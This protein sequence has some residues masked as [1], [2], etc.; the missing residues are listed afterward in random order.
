MNRLVAVLAALLVLAPILALV[1][2]AHEQ[3]VTPAR[4]PAALLLR[5]EPVVETSGGTAVAPAVRFEVPGEDTLFAMAA[6][7]AWAYVESQYQPNT[8]F[9]NSVINYPYATIWDMGSSLAALHCAEALGLV[10]GDEYDRRMTRALQTLENLRLFDGAGF[11]KTYQL[12]NG[13]PA[14]RDDRDR[15]Y[16]AG[17]Y[18]WSVTDIGRLLVWLKIISLDR[19]EYA[20]QIERIVARLDFDRLVREGYLWGSSL[21]RSGSPWAYQEG[22][23]GY[24]QYAA[25]GFA[26]WDQ[27]AD[28]ALDLRQ[29][30]REVEVLGVPILTDRRGESRLTSEPFFMMGLELGW[31]TPEWRELAER[32]L[33]VQENRYRETGRLTMVSED[34]M[35]HPPYYFYYYTLFHEGEDFAVTA[36][37]P[38]QKFANPRW[39]STKAAFAWYA[40]M[41]DPYTWQVLETVAG[42]A[43]HPAVGWSSGV[44]EESLEPTGS[45]NINTSA[46]ILEA[47]LYHQRQRPLLAAR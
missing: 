9:A 14:G 30:T 20:T 2:P 27:F 11:N 16:A 21:N 38:G 29:N 3:P 24:E 42:R 36:V 46:I 6:R 25:A 31:W 7:R 43:A 8:G 10:E 26:L 1:L 41:P 37:V 15:Q 40:L 39:V 47:A 32:L 5:D 12:R 22:R 28:R 18:G 45:Q 33:E 44:Y 35:P 13:A 34:A 17:G 23:I 4:P 19:P